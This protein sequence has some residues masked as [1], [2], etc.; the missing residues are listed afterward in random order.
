MSTDAT[1]GPC[2]PEFITVDGARI[3]VRS[4]GRIAASGRAGG[5]TV[6]IG[7][8]LQGQGP[9]PT[10]R[11]VIV[12]RDATILAD[13]LGQGT[14]G[15]TIIWSDEVTRFW[16]RISARGGPEGGDGGFAEVSS[17]GW[18]DYRGVVDLRATLGQVGV[19][20]LD[21][22]DLMIANVESSDVTGASPFEPVGDVG[23]SILDVGVLVAQFAAVTQ[24][25]FAACVADVEPCLE[26]LMAEVS[27]LD[28]DNQ[29]DQWNRIIELMV[30]PTTTTVALG[31]FDPERMDADYK[32]VETYFDLEKPFD[33]KTAYTNEFLDESIKMPAR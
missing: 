30:D 14:G 27:G 15:T 29:V 18:L 1:A 11:S 20:L 7:G 5:G 3:A 8:D 33:V 19:L 23:L 4:G 22:T 13:A 12:D 31:A 16:G 32:T 9:G 24:R 17:K 28:H 2:P 6:K 10:A 21:P 25:A 26:A